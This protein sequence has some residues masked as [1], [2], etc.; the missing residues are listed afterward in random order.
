VAFTCLSYFTFV[1]KEIEF[2]KANQI[3]E[4]FIFS[5][6]LCFSLVN[7]FFFIPTYVVEEGTP[8]VYPILLNVGLL[9]F[10]AFYLLE[11]FLT[12]KDSDESSDEAQENKLVKTGRV[13]VLLVL[14]GIWIYIMEHVGFLLS[15]A[16]F[17]FLASFCYGSRELIK[18]LLVST[19]LPLTIYLI[20]FAVGSALPE[21][22]F[23][24]TLRSWISG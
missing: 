14:M 10:G 21:G 19:I 4:V 17:L 23:D 5:G 16:V 6:V 12:G 20:F 22:L 13:I 8:A 15:S 1:Q 3:R 7:H 9:V 11:I 2:M 24:Q 18:I